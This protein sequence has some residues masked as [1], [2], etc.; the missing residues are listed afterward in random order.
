MSPAVSSGVHDRCTGKKLRV[1]AS[2]HWILGH[3]T[4][5]CSVGLVKNDRE[6]SV[7]TYG[8]PR[9]ELWCVAQA[10]DAM[11]SL[12]S[13]LQ[14]LTNAL[15]SYVATAVTTI[16]SNVTTRSAI[17]ITHRPLIA[18]FSRSPTSCLLSGTTPFAPLVG[19]Q[20]CCPHCTV[21]PA[22]ARLRLE[23]SNSFGV[24]LYRLESLSAGMERLEAGMGM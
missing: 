15:G 18:C 24:Q 11:R 8:F 10:P 4:D 17:P 23:L 3:A 20:T 12:A 13:A 14:L 2:K 1:V 19:L 9:E 5:R 22:C 16:V 7:V 21:F 6:S